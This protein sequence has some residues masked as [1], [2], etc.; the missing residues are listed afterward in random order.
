MTTLSNMKQQRTLKNAV[1]SFA[2][3]LIILAL[4]L[5]VPRLFIINY[6]SDVN[7][8]TSTI[9]QIFTYMALLEAGI[10][11]AA[12][13]ALYNPIAKN[14]R[15]GVSYYI[16]VANRY[17]H[18]ITY[19]YLSA[20][21][22]LSFI[23]P[24]VLKTNV[25][26]WTI[27]FYTLFEGLVGVVLFYFI[28]TW[29]CF[30]G[31]SGKSYIVN[32]ITL[33]SKILCYGVKI[34][35]AVLGYNIAFIQL[36]YF[37][38]SMLQLAFFAFYMSK[39]YPWIRYNAAPKDAKLPDRN[40]YIVTEITWTIFSSTD[41]IVLSIFVS[42]SLSSV[43]S[44][45]NM[46]FVALNGLLNS[47]YHSVNYNL[48]NAFHENMEKYKKMHDLFNSC[49]MCGITVLMSTAYFLI[50][51]FVKLYTS[52][53]TDINYIYYFLPICFCLVQLF[54]WSRYIS[55]N[56]IG[57]AGRIKPALKINII[58]AFMNV[59]LSVLFVFFWDITGVLI[60]TVVALPLKIIYCNY[61]AD[62]VILKRSLKK[63]VAILMVNYFV[64]SISI[65]LSHFLTIDIANY[66]Q[67]ILYGI[68]IFTS[69][70]IISFVLNAFINKDLIKSFK[71]IK[72]RGN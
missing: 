36:G 58:E 62:K 65:L 61:I 16:S 14:D 70:A 71:Y 63:T 8:L 52:G 10:S 5:I 13:N 15:D 6:G 47:I 22:L 67:F 34:V 2:S 33:I 1:V 43:Y 29:T 11:Q 56:L 30:L 60:A 19:F 64:F 35:F 44:V 42:T 7:G 68:V 66:Y 28:N 24:F 39:K 20:V 40:S 51:P 26:Y 72:N 54:S 25:D 23:L 45:Y 41:M 27:C 21:I 32:S 46:V 50:I 49:F 38:V 17:F 48:G 4:G 69:F 18:K 55:G 12:R 3:Q 53:V 57:I 59:T 9:G 37:A 31:A